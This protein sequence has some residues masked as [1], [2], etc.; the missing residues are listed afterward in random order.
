MVSPQD[1]IDILHA[2]SKHGIQVWVSGGWGIDALLREETRPHKDLDILMLVDDVQRMRDVLSGVGYRLKEIW[3][4]NAW[5][6]DLRGAR[7]PTAFVLQ[8]AVGRELDAHAMR[9]D[10]RGNGIPAWA[11]AGLVLTWEDLGA[12]GRIVGLSVRCITAEA[13]VRLHTGYDLPN[14][15]RRDMRLLHERLGVVL[16]D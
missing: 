12:R 9:L 1:V 4:E 7:V 8:D 2:L 11:E 16:V 13:Q 14:E 10:N 3:A 5:T 15:Q 6:I